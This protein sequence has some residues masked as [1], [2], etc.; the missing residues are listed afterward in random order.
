MTEAVR[1]DADGGVLTV[2]L[3]RPKANAIDVATSRA[4][5]EAFVRLRDDDSLRVAVVTGAGERFFSAGWDLKAGEEIDAD[6]G[7][8]GFAG[9]TEFF[10]LD[11][12]VIAAV[13]GL[14]LGGGFELALAADLVVAAEHAE[15]AL[16]E[17]TLGMVADSGGVLRLPERLPR[18]VAAEMLLTGRRM[19]AAEGHR[20]GLVTSVV[21]ASELPAEAAALAHRIRAGAPLAVAAVK[22]ILRETAALDV[23]SGYRLL[24]GGGLPNYRAMLASEDAR[25]GPR[26][27]AEKRPPQWTGR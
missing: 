12:P 27:F 19:T 21:P 20:W 8:G 5:H 14:A 3:D 25:E 26:A 2:T 11:K 10:D 18:A 22:E 13:N 6:H 15:F 7:P 24:R 23:E 16:T 1:T 9:L 4:L 17:V